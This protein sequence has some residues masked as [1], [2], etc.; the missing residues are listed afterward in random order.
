MSKKHSFCNLPKDP[1][2]SFLIL[3]TNNTIFSFI[4]TGLE[5]LVDQIPSMEGD[6]GVFSA[7]GGNS[8]GSHP[9]T[10]RSVG[11]YSPGA[12]HSQGFPGA[13]PPGAGPFQQPQPPSAPSFGAASDSNAPAGAFGGIHS[14]NYFPEIKLILV[15]GVF[16]FLPFPGRP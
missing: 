12:F 8:A 7:S 11:P 4:H 3:F 5:S 13:G 2:A 1:L 16:L 10:P 14:F 9:N 6:S 15:E